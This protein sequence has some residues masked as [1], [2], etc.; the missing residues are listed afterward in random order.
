MHK[1]HHPKPNSDR[2][3]KTSIFVF[4]ISFPYPWS[5]GVVVCYSEKVKIHEKK[6]NFNL[7]QSA[8]EEKMSNSRKNVF[9]VLL[10][11]FWASDLW[12]RINLFLCASKLVWGVL[13]YLS[14]GF[15]AAEIRS[16]KKKSLFFDLPLSR[17]GW[18]K[19]R[20][21]NFFEIPKKNY[22]TPFSR[23]NEDLFEVRALKRKFAELNW[24]GFQWVKYFFHFP[25]FPTR[26]PFYLIQKLLEFVWNWR[27]F[28]KISLEWKTKISR[29]K[30]STNL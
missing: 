11:N 27:L 30:S 17:K 1:C 13:P 26:L 8:T 28:W 4:R 12:N 6:R 24:Y 3:S 25:S 5:G 15:W 20:R 14:F 23:K 10:C 19:W 29:E 16:W 9:S 21:K 2:P 22:C 7:Q 18:K